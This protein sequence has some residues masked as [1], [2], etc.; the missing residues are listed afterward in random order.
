MGRHKSAVPQ[1]QISVRMRDVESRE[2]V[3]AATHASGYLPRICY[4][5][6]CM[7]AAGKLERATEIRREAKP[8]RGAA[9]EDGRLGEGSDGVAISFFVPTDEAEWIDEAAA[10]CGL[11]R[12]AWLQRVFRAAAGDKDTLSSVRAEGANLVSQLTRARSSAG[13][14]HR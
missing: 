13:K 5:I 2:L 12:A 9:L 4:R 14:G 11:A 8:T 3:R 6:W 7:T 1:K 10:E